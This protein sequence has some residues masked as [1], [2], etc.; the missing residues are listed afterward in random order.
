MQNF[1]LNLNDPH[2]NYVDVYGDN[3][4][5][6]GQFTMSG[7]S[8]REHALTV[9]TATLAIS[10]WNPSPTDEI[11]SVSESGGRIFLG[12]TFSG[13]QSV[14]R[15][16]LAAFDAVTGA[17]F[18]SNPPL[19]NIL[20][21]RKMVIRGDSLFLLGRT[22]LP[23]DAIF[24]TPSNFLLY[25][26][27]TGMPLTVPNMNI[28]A[29]HD[30]L[31]DGNYLY[32]AADF[33]VRRFG[34][35]GLSEDALWHQDLSGYTTNLEPQ[36]LCKDSANIYV[37]GDNR[38]TAP[39][40]I[41]I[42]DPDHAN[43]VRIDKTNSSNYQL[44]RYVDT[45]K[46]NSFSAPQFDRA[47]L[48]DSILY[49]QGEFNSLNGTM[50]RGFTAIDVHNGKP[51]SWSPSYNYEK[52]DV[53]ATEFDAFSKLI[54]WTTALY[55]SDRV[56]FSPLSGPSIRRRVS[57]FLLPLRW[58]EDGTNTRVNFLPAILRTLEARSMISCSTRIIVM[59]PADS[60]TS[61]GNCIRISFV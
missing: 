29:M 56:S 25:S 30:F 14:H 38:D 6:S 45:L 33:G 39:W 34:L 32:V 59:W 61:M 2:A 52:N 10:N 26:I 43:L 58:M 22:D 19:N 13:I 18:P 7:D 57:F 49:I 8:A 37:V 48:A 60:I 44:W 42:E 53:E 15:N 16:G 27:S 4:L 11:R 47:V 9:D 35:P 50:A 23:N 51:L 12:G 28:Q 3:L 31:I 40:A 21:G 17:V 5:I 55:G 54:P 20:Y 36:Y 1:N 41:F 24:P 46:P